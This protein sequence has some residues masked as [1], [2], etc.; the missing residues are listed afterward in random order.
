M[1]EGDRAGHWGQQGGADVAASLLRRYDPKARTWDLPR[2][3]EFWEAVSLAH[4]LGR[5]GAGTTIAVVDDGFATDI[6]AIADQQLMW[7]VPS[8]GMTTHGTVVALLVAQV[9][10]S[11]RLRLYPVARAGAW[12]PELI[13]SA[14]GT[15]SADSATVINMSFGEAFPVDSLALSEQVLSLDSGSTGAAHED[16]LFRLAERLAALG[17]WRSLVRA[18]ATRI[19]VA[20]RAAAGAG[21]VVM[22]ASGNESSHAF[23]PAL[24]PSVFSIAF[25]RASRSVVDGLLETAQSKRPTFDESEFSDFGLLQPTGVL[26][27]SFATPLLS[28]FAALMTDRRELAGFRDSATPSGFADALAITFDPGERWTPTRHGVV[29]NLYARALDLLPH[30][31]LDAASHGPCPECSFFGVPQ[32]I[33]FGLWKFQWGDLD[34]AER[35]LRAATA[36]APSNPHGYAN[37]GVVCGVRAKAAKE[38]MSLDVASRYLREAVS[39]FEHAVALRPDDEPYRRRLAEFSAAAEAPEAWDMVP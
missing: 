38:R 13:E 3:G 24:E 35:L 15:S 19:G 22:A 25:F 17:G 1:V 32:Y 33:N 10:P 9:A 16:R 29:D 14:I 6:P 12:D 21:S 11:A 34:G 39:L 7:P 4:D 30:K 23:S 2:A 8:G 5:S 27:S 20:A 36:F 18:P 26:G 28:G 31:H 37:L